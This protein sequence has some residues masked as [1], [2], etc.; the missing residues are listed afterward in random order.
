MLGPPLG[1]HFFSGQRVTRAECVVVSIANSQYEKKKFFS[2]GTFKNTLLSLA[3]STL[4][5]LK[6]DFA[7]F[8]RNVLLGPSPTIYQLDLKEGY[9]SWCS[10]CSFYTFAD[11]NLIRSYTVQRGHWWTQAWKF[12]K[13]RP[14]DSGP[15]FSALQNYSAI[16]LPSIFNC[17]IFMRGVIVRSQYVFIPF[18]C[19]ITILL[20]C[21]VSCI[22]RL[23]GMRFWYGAHSTKCRLT[24]GVD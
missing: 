12:N 13:S 17:I 10:L 16:C 21:F 9:C 7:F 19:G 2:F 4:L 11:N 3:V 1:R 24:L 23:V 8:D 15:W 5:M 20:Y 18:L 22:R 6:G 14:I